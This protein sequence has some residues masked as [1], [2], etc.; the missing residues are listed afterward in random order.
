VDPNDVAAMRS[1]PDG[2]ELT[3]FMRRWGNQNL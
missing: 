3:A 2:R 1:M